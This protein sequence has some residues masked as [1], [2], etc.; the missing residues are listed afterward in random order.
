MSPP[1]PHYEL[2]DWFSQHIPN[3]RSWLRPFMGRKHVYALEI[4]SCEGR[5]ATW[6]LEHVLT[7]EGS[8]LLCVD[9]FD[10]RGSAAAGIVGSRASAEAMF[11]RFI[12]NVLNVH[13]NATHERGTSFDVLRNYEP[14]ALFDVVY[15]D[16]GHNARNVLEDAIL[17]W[18]L[19]RPGG[20]VIFDDYKW[21]DPTLASPEREWNRPGPAIDAFLSAYRKDYVILGNERGEPLGWQVA[22][23]RKELAP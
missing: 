19:V 22:V 18:P 2:P 4:G 11:S 17:T 8:N 13:P 9:P 20:V 1:A 6:L 16:G 23:K 15:I 21:I 5:S 10:H 14:L 7:G 3:W 12:L